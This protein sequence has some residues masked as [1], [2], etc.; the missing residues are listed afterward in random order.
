MEDV[1]QTCI[2]CAKTTV[3]T[4]FV[5]DYKVGLCIK[6]FN[7]S[8]KIILNVI[9]GQQ[10]TKKEMKNIYF[11]ENECVE[12]KNKDEY[13]SICHLLRNP[14]PINRELKQS[15]YLEHANSTTSGHS[16]GYTLKPVST[17]TGEPLKVLSFE[18][19]LIKT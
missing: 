12:I 18:E 3:S 10:Q 4:R 16:I 9:I 5:L 14:N 1:S 11:S 17:W 15:I 19:A 7:I 2:F 8:N 13:N 6:H